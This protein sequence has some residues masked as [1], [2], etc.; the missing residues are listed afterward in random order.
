MVQK[1]KKE[2]ELQLEES[3]PKTMPSIERLQVWQMTA[4]GV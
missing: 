1:E 3:S 4:H 2:E